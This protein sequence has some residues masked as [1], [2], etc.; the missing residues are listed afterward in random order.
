M[1]YIKK[2][3]TAKKYAWEPAGL[4]EAVTA[5]RKAAGQ[6]YAELVA[7][8]NEYI[9]DDTMNYTNIESIDSDFGFE[10][11][12]SGITLGEKSPKQTQLSF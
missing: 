10:L 5:V 1:T 3:A 7:H 2:F 6:S 4:Y 8:G 12:R 11:I 9:I